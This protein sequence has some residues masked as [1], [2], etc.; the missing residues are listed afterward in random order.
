MTPCGI[1]ADSVTARLWRGRPAKIV[2]KMGYSDKASEYFKCL[3]LVTRRE[4]RVNKLVKRCI[5]G[6]CPQFFK[7]YFTFNRS[8]SS[9]HDQ[10]TTQMNKLHLP[11]VRTDIVKNLFYI[12]AV[13]Y[14]PI[15]C[16]FHR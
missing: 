15:I 5:K 3:S 4:K 13:I 2:S 6:Q 16:S 8:V 10:T 7:N 1:A 9:V 14:L 11:R 12:M